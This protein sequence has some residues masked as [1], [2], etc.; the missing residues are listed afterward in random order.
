[1]ALPLARGWFV[2][3]SIAFFPQRKHRYTISRSASPTYRDAA[4][5]MEVDERGGLG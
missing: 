4:A 1:M 2:L 3:K 5:D